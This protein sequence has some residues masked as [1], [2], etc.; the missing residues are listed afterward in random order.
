MVTASHAVIKETFEAALR[1]VGRGKAWTFPQVSK[2]VF[3]EYD[4]EALEQVLLIAD[5]KVIGI[6]NQ[7]HGLKI[8]S[9]RFG[10]S[11]VKKLTVKIVEKWKSAYA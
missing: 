6:K 7:A 2:E 10:M 9:F 3:L 8:S 11:K 4:P 5:N 1:G